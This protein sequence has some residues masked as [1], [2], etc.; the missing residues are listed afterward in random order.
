MPLLGLLSTEDFASERFTSIRRSV[1]Y[2]YPN[3]AAPLLGLLSMLDG[4]VLN[5]PE[6]SWYEDRLKELVTTTVVNGTTSGAW[7]ADST[8]SLGSAMATTAADRTAGTAYW[9]RVA[10]LTPFRNNDIVKLRN[11]NVT[12][13]T[14]D[15]QFKILANS[16]GVWSNTNSTVYH[17]RVTPINTIANVLNVYN[18]SD[19]GTEVQVLGNANMQGQTGSAEGAYS[20]PT[21]TG[22]NAQI[23]RTPFSFTGTALRTSAKFDESGPYKDKAKKASM[24]HMIQMELQFLFGEPSKSVDSATGLPTY[25]TGGII[26]FLRLWEA[27]T[28]NAVAG[29][30]STYPVAASTQNTD[31]NKRIIEINGNI[32]DSALDDYYERLFRH[33]NNISNEKLAFCGSGF[34]NILNKLFKN[35]VTLNSDLPLADTYGMNVVKH[36][37][38]FGTVYYK[39][40]PLFNRNAFMRYNALFLDVQNFKYRYVQD[41]DTDIKKNCQPNNADYRLDEFLTEAGLELQFPEANMY[42]KGVT[43]IA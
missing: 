18:Q 26:F 11:M 3:G 8:G 23:F 7:Y 5:D 42:M 2:Q 1:F 16:S 38:P 17:I 10:S 9:L 25:T 19:A 14:V 37:C 29:V 28:G 15:A 33:T 22:N 35:E 20:M 32:T 43:G 41:R 12:G 4:E 36:V 39:T 40:H 13:A 6:F 24:S 31:D 27:G 34:L 21:R 30:T